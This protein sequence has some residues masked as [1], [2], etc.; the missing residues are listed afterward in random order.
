MWTKAGARVPDPSREVFVVFLEALDA[1]FFL[2]KGVDGAGCPRRRGLARVSRAPRS[3]ETFQLSRAV[4]QTR[5]D[6]ACAADAHGEADFKRF[7]GSRARRQHDRDA[8]GPP[9]DELLNERFSTR[10]E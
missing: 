6:H 8:R 2:P 4:S 1:E 9:N 7:A 10:Q 5:L 3:P